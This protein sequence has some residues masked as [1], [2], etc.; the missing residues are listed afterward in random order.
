MNHEGESPFE[1]WQFSQLHSLLLSVSTVKSPVMEHIDELGPRFLYQKTAEI[2]G[3]MAKNKATRKLP[4]SE[5]KIEVLAGQNLTVSLAGSDVKLT[6]HHGGMGKPRIFG[7][8]TSEMRAVTFKRSGDSSVLLPMHRS[9][10]TFE[11][12]KLLCEIRDQI[13]GV[14]FQMSPSPPSYLD[15]GEDTTIRTKKFHLKRPVE[16]LCFLARLSKSVTGGGAISFATMSAAT[17]KPTH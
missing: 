12:F 9:G 5:T 10:D 17:R 2:K 15:P 13:Y 8:G 4:P 6:I 11:F 3:I 16:P 7:V 1:N 14:T